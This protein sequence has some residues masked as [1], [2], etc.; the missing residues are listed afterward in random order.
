MF[1]PLGIEP[2]QGSCL[3]LL[4][5]HSSLP[6]TLQTLAVALHHFSEVICTTV[7]VFVCFYPAE[8]YYVT[9][10]SLEITMQPKL[11]LNA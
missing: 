11:A 10:T 4:W 9:R 8:S 5:L 2:G 3:I 1:Y 7:D 6:L